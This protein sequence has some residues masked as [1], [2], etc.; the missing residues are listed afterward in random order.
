MSTSTVEETPETRLVARCLTP[1]C[2]WKMPAS[3]PTIY[4]LNQLWAFA[5]SHAHRFTH[6]MQVCPEFV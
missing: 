1:Q 3:G 5:K 4:D 2:G 6:D